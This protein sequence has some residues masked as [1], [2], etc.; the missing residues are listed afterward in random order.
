M[1]QGHHEKAGKHTY[2]RECLIYKVWDPD[3]HPFLPVSIVL[4]D[5]STVTSFGFKIKNLKE[6]GIESARFGSGENYF[7]PLKFCLHNFFVDIE[8]FLL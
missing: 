1:N 7:C 4:T 3:L 5:R 6:T 2:H 8:S